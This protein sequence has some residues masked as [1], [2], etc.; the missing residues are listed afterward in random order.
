MVLATPVGAPVIA[1]AGMPVKPPA[2]VTVTATAADV[3]CAMLAV[4]GLSA[5]LMLSAGACVFPLSPHD[6]TRATAAGTSSADQ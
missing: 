1:S 2:P 3:P 5:M 4:V 6:C